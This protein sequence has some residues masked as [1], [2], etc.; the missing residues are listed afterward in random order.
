MPSTIYVTSI[1]AAADLMEGSAPGTY[2][3]EYLRALAE[4][5]CGLSGINSEEVLSVQST[6][7]DIAGAN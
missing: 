1:N 4:M 6:I 7:L 5:V 2:H 3:P